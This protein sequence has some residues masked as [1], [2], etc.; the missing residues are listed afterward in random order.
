M[1]QHYVPSDSSP[2]S[3]CLELFTYT[4]LFK[5]S[6]LAG[7]AGQGFTTARLTIL[8]TVCALPTFTQPSHERDYFLLELRADSFSFGLLL[9]CSPQALGQSW[10]K[11]QRCAAVLSSQ[12][13]KKHIF[14]LFRLQ[15]A[16][17]RYRL[18]H[19]TAHTSSGQST[20]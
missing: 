15:P 17:H 14:F 4:L 18:A 10:G 5:G 1:V 6:D 8:G 12:C 19:S 3:I 13:G 2:Y 11:G 7:S 20:K 9:Q 16:R